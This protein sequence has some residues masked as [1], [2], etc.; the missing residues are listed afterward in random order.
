MRQIQGIRREDL[1][2][3]CSTGKQGTKTPILPR[4]GS[5][6]V[7]IACGLSLAACPVVLGQRT[8]EDVG[9]AS[10]LLGAEIVVIR[11]GRL[12]YRLQ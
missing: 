8:T 3:D 9:A 1:L 11:L 4:R 6:R 10:I 7:R 5:E 2:G 12:D